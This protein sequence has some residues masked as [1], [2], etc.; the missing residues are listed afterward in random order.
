[1]VLN[2]GTVVATKTTIRKVINDPEM[3]K[4]NHLHWF[5]ILKT[6]RCGGSRIKIGKSKNIIARLKYYQSYFHASEVEVLELRSF[7][8]HSRF[9]DRALF[10]Y[11]VYEEEAKK[12]LRQYSDESISNGDGKI[13]EWFKATHQ[14]ALMKTYQEFVNSFKQLNVAKTEQKKPK[15]RKV[16]TVVNY[17]EKSEHDIFQEEPSARAPAAPAAPR[18]VQKVQRY[19]P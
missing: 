9:T 6:P 7:S 4:K 3:Q 16:K 5:Y 11:D 19:T 13:T 15:E 1:M 12:A 17:K 2:E 8:K 14:E 18:Q 10:L